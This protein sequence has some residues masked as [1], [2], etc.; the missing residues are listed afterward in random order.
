LEEFRK[1]WG[2]SFNFSVTSLPVTGL[3]QHLPSP[4]LVWIDTATSNLGGGHDI[5]Q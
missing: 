4:H 3:L 2:Y 1:L 5:A